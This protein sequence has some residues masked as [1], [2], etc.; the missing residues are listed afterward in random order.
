[1]FVEVQKVEAQCADSYSSDGSKSDISTQLGRKVRKKK[2]L[3]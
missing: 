1:M 3:K 2:Y